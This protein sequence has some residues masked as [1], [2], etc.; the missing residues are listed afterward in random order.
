MPTRPTRTAPQ[1]LRQ[2]KAAY[3]QQQGPR[4]SEHEQRQIDRGA[5]LL[6]RAERAKE[7]ERRKK[8]NQR[9]REEKERKERK[10]RTSIGIGLATQ[11]AGYSHTQVAMKKGMETFLGMGK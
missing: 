1:T 11:L 10:A 7:Q 6:R 4:L 3:K 2:A 8:E 9:R 5:E